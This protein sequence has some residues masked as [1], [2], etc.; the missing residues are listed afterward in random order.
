MFF[1]LVLKKERSMTNTDSMLTHDSTINHLQ[2]KKWTAIRVSNK[3]EDKRPNTKKARRR[4]KRPLEENDFIE[5]VIVVLANQNNNEVMNAPIHNEYIRQV[6]E[7]EKPPPLPW[8]AWLR[9]N[10]SSFILR[11]T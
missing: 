1:L 10:K 9:G 7:Y 8:W 4:K 2:Y 6:P 11:R 5:E 3:D